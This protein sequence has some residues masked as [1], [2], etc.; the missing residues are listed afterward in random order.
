MLRVDARARSTAL[1]AR[2]SGDHA[3]RRCPTSRGC[4]RGRWWRR[5]RSSPT[6]SAGAAV[7]RAAARR[8]RAALRVR[9]V[10][11]GAREPDPDPDAGDEAEPAS[12]RAPRRSRAR[13]AALGQEM[14]PPVTVPH[15][16][17]A[18]A[19]AIR[20]AEGEMVL[21]LGG[22][23]TSDAA[24]VCPAGLV[25]AGG[26]LVRFGMPVDP[27]N[28]LFLGEHGG[29]P[30]VGLPGCA[31][32]PAVNGADWV[33]ERL[34]AGIAGRRRRDRGDGRGRAPEGDPGAAAA[35]RGPAGGAGA[36]AGGGDR[37]GGGRGAADARARQAARAGGRAA[38]A[39]RGGGGGAGE[40]G[41][42]GGGGAAAG[43]RRRGGRRSTGST[44]AIVEAADW[45]EGMAA[46]IRAGLAA[47]GGEADAVVILLADMPEV[48]A[49]RDRPADRGLRPGG[50]ARDLPGG[51]RRR[52]R[53]GIRC[54]SGGGSSRR[55]PGSTAT[56]GRARCC[57]RRR[58][59]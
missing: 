16:A 2:R 56:A 21:I 24:D 40:P 55:W 28:L 37:A 39:A 10:P 48:G 4:G 59:S 8:G 7:A 44:S 32:S 38:G 11:A 49:R 15:E 43:R 14:A 46:S 31:R 35:A 34:A 18:V 52:R 29:R 13:L 57:A 19:A 50:G 47:V 12:P 26:R 42:R 17:A 54:C 53:R 58:S 23:A 6:P 9:G 33:L 36:A 27:G 25:A 20:A 51:Q 30:V 41:R 3:R 5:S 45:A 22:S 1:N